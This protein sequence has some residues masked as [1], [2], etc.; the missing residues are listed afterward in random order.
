MNNA[1]VYD[2]RLKPGRRLLQQLIGIRRAGEFN[3]RVERLVIQTGLREWPK[4]VI[5]QLLAGLLEGAKR[6]DLAEH[7]QDFERRHPLRHGHGIAVM[8]SL[9]PPN[10]PRGVI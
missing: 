5:E 2:P 4:R 9:A 8:R 6:L 7:H 1:P 3:V 10:V